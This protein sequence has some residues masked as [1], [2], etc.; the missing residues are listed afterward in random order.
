MLRKI[1]LVN[2]KEIDK[3]NL[4]KIKGG[5]WCCCANCVCGQ[6]PGDSW[7]DDNARTSRAEEPV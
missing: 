3:K 1:K 5:A 6:N 4:N 2:D 7:S